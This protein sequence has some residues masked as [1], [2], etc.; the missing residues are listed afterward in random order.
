LHS[1]AVGDEELLLLML[2][3]MLMPMLRWVKSWMIISL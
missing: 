3:L 1:A 2:M